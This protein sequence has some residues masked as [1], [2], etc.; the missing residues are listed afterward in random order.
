M[1]IASII[2][3][4]VEIAGED[5]GYTEGKN[6]ANHFAKM[7]GAP[8]YAAYCAIGLMS[9][10]SR[11]GADIHKAFTTP[12]YVP[13]I[14]AQAKARGWSADSP[15][16][17]GDIVVYDWQDNPSDGDH[18]GIATPSK[19]RGAA[20]EYNT[21]P[22][23]AGSQGNGGG[24]YRRTRKDNVIVGY[25]LIRKV[26][27]AINIADSVAVDSFIARGPNLREGDWGSQVVELQALLN[28]KGAGIA[29]DGKYGP[30]TRNA[31]MAVQRAYRLDVDGVVGPDTFAALRAVQ[32]P[33]RSKVRKGDSGGDVAE[34][35]RLVGVQA[36]GKYGPK[37]DAAV[38][39]FQR[40]Q[41]LSADG[42]V[43][44]DTWTRL[45][46]VRVSC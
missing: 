7:V 46:G 20:I 14:W 36:D 3:K 4:S 25:V 44:P 13:G 42:V 8:N 17:D 38:K 15:E 30:R 1:S 18:V 35:Q 5:V 22:S 37:T 10:F 26:L 39:H 28:A 2:D 41:G 33:V 45:I 27:A 43:G 24:V 32:P 40:S 12:W 31:V 9:A 19:G 11:G 21:S 6:N 23:N 29:A 34:V 16:R